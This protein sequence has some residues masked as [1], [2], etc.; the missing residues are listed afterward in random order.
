MMTDHKRKSLE[1]VVKDINKEE[2]LKHRELIQGFPIPADE[3]D[4]LLCME[5]E[6]WIAAC[7]VLAR[8]AEAKDAKSAF[9]F[10]VVDGIKVKITRDRVTIN[11]VAVT[12]HDIP[13]KIVPAGGITDLKAQIIA[14]CNLRNSK[15]Y[16][17]LEAKL[18]EVSAL[19]QEQD[20]LFRKI[21]KAFKRL[22]VWQDEI[23]SKYSKVAVPWQGKIVLGLVGLFFLVSGILFWV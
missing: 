16:S 14:Y 5:R 21:G 19:Q 4:K 10:N 12:Y 22:V 13:S 23:L 9:T 7:S 1:E 18:A 8:A 2:D 11:G 20:L 15:P 6:Y 17:E 3:I